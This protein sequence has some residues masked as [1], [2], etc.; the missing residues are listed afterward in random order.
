[1]VP[2]TA[3]VATE[4]ILMFDDP[5]L[6]TYAVL[7]SGENAIPV[8]KRPVSVKPSIARVLVLVKPMPPL[9]SS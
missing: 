5:W 7:P 6:A 2:M 4:T 3:R 8:G 9:K 1:M